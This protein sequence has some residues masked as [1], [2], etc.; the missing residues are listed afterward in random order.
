MSRFRDLLGHGADPSEH[1]PQ[2]GAEHDRPLHPDG[3]TP[4]RSRG[5]GEAPAAPDHAATP[6]APAAPGGPP[7]PPG[8]T[9]EPT[10]G[11]LAGPPPAGS[12][13]APAG[14][15][16][17]PA[18]PWRLHSPSTAAPTIGKVL[19][20]PRPVLAPATAFRRS[21][22]SL[23]SVFVGGFHVAAGSLVG[24]AHLV[25]GSPCQDAYDFAVSPGGRLV[26]AIADGL[27]S[28]PHS[29]VGAWSFCEGVIRAGFGRDTLT[30]ADLL[31]Y[32]AGYAETQAGAY[33]LT[34]RDIAFV[35]AVATFD[36]RRCEIARVGDVS[37]FGLVDGQFQ[38]LLAHAGDEHVNVVTDTLPEQPQPEPEVRRLEAVG[39]VVLCTDGL[40]TDLRN[41]PGVRG[42]LAESWE[43]PGDVHAMGEALRFR[44][45][46]SHDDR[47]A[48]VISV[49]E[50]PVAADSSATSV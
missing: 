15:P 13:E 14:E 41:S 11:E 50:D 44:R 16:T 9:A 35:G 34:P 43:T 26:V 18:D 21:M 31:A 33:R 27:G 20:P 22:L 17:R 4:L 24:T 42:W 38:E 28:R 45:R 49:V 1:S 37:A 3:A 19:P 5:A 47:T 36:G 2:D 10:P 23:D 29:Q 46:G 30:A 25:S 39:R 12:A 7:E 6:A 40:A 8:G 48:V 32:A